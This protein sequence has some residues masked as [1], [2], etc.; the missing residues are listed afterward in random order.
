MPKLSQSKII[1]SFNF[2]CDN[3][4]NFMQQYCCGHTEAYPK[5]WNTW[6][7]EISWRISFYYSESQVS[8]DWWVSSCCK[9]DR[10]L[11]SAKTLL[12]LSQCLWVQV[13]DRFLSRIRIVLVFVFQAVAF[14]LVY[15]QYLLQGMWR[16]DTWL[17]NQSCNCY[18][19][20]FR[21]ACLGMFSL[22]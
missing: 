3:K 4:I 11:T 1:L 19:L 18:S 22:V 6:S 21:P 10:C 16:P 12:L 13:Y 8:A 5:L 7:A 20:P 2:V 14:G 9:A 15:S 17:L